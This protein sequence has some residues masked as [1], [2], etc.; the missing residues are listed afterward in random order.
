MLQVT[1]TAKE[2]LQD[3]LEKNTGKHVRIY[4]KGVG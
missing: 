3:I 4:V 2:R 1:D